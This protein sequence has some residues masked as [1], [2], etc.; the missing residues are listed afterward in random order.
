MAGR[1]LMKPLIRDPFFASSLRE[2]RKLYDELDHALMMPQYW[3]GKSLT[4]SHK[5]GQGCP[6]IVD[7]EKEFKVKMDVSH[8]TPE[9]LKVS[10]KNKC[11]QVEA[12]HEEKSDE[13]GTI[14]RSFVRRYSLPPGIKEENVTSELNKDGILTIGGA[15][16]EIE[17]DK[18]K[19]VPIKLK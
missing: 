1:W 13:Y 17:E 4:D 8:F 12:E 10:I 7:N 16:M 5:F 6:E 18:T 3:H 19:E 11:L 2:A 9:E 14:K 15:K